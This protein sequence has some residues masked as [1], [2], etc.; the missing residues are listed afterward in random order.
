MKEHDHE[1]CAHISQKGNQ[2]HKQIHQ[3]QNNFKIH[4]PYLKDYQMKNGV[5]M[6][7]HK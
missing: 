2:S 3:G 7:K 5:N 6:P 1:Q 4:T